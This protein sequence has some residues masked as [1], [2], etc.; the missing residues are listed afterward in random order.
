[1]PCPRCGYDLTSVTGAACPNCGLPLAQAQQP[2]A[3]QA[4]YPP[5]GYPGAQSGPYAQPSYQPTS[6]QPPSYGTPPGYPTNPT[7]PTNPGYPTTP[8]A[9]GYPTGYPAGAPP[10]VPLAPGGYPPQTYYSQPGTGPSPFAPPPKRGNGPLIGI[11]VAIAL[12]AVIGGGAAY[13]IS[14]SGNPTTSGTPG[15]TN[16]AGPTAT[17]T[18]T[19]LYQQAFTSKPSDWPD[20]AHCF[21]GTGGY[22]I[23]G[24]YFCPAPIGNQTDTTISVNVKQISGATNLPYGIVFRIDDSN[25]HYEL[26]VDSEGDY[27]FYNCDISTCTK[28]VDYTPNSAIHGGLN[29]TNTMSVTAKGSHFDFF[30]NGT[31]VGQTDDTSYTSGE[32]GIAGSDGAECVFTNFLVTKAS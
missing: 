7:Y 10:S 11:I 29:T 20:S 19:V 6:E 13:A 16:T 14:R 18:A 28:L 26:D 15:V 23:S 3:T 24:S 27:V 12:I 25:E 1:M 4:S 32:L 2:G 9:P 17:P 21:F 22:H 8:A 30:V 5:S 31:K